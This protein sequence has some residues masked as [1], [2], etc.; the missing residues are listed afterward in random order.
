MHGADLP[1]ETSATF[2]EVLHQKQKSKSFS[3]SSKEH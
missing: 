3:D 2:Y 1:L